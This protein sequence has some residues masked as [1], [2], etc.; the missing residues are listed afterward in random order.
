MYFNLTPYFQITSYTMNIT[1]HQSGFRRFHATETLI[2]HIITD[3][4]GPLFKTSNAGNIAD[5]FDVSALF[6]TLDHSV[7]LQRLGDL[8]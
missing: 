2:M 3:V 8:F 5:Y 6:D 4:F 1:L 7:L